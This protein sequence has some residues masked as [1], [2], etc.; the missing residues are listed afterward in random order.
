VGQ[1]TKLGPGVWINKTNLHNDID[2]EALD[3]D[4][5]RTGGPQTAGIRTGL[6]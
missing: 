5:Q 2:S 4:T 1:R 6:G 3:S